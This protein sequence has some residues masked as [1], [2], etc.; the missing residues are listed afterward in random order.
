MADS[1]NAKQREFWPALCNIENTVAQHVTQDVVKREKQKGPRTP[2]SETKRLKCSGSKYSPV[3]PF[4]A[5][6][7]ISTQLKRLCGWWVLGASLAWSRRRLWSI[8]SR[9][10]SSQSKSRGW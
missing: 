4:P 6:E 1:K 10:N 5:P 8:C 3:T 7:G 2:V 9:I